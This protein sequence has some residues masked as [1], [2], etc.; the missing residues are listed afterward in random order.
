[1]GRGW[2]VVGR[3][4]TQK[5]L[6]VFNYDYHWRDLSGKPKE[7]EILFGKQR[8]KLPLMISIFFSEKLPSMISKLFSISSMVASCHGRNWKTAHPNG[9]LLADGFRLD[10][11]L[12]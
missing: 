2:W 8:I 9:I 4:I 5:L 3:K 11:K 7:I 1:M 6:I 10:M 12:T